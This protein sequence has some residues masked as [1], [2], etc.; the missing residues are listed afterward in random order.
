MICTMKWALVL[1][2]GGAKGLAYIG[3]LKAFEELGFPA[4]DFIAGCSMGGIIGGLYAS[5]M[6][7]REMEYFF[8]HEFSIE[9]Y[10]GNI[11]WPLSAS[12]FARFL[13]LGAGIPH[14]LSSG[15]MDSGERSHL[16]FSRLSN[17]QTFE[18]LTIPFACNA[19]DLYSGK[20]IILHSGPLAAALRATSS[21]PG[22]FAPMPIGDYL[23]VDGYILHNTPVW[24]AREYGFTNIIAVTLSSFETVKRKD[25]SNAAHVL[26]R[27][28][29]VAV[30]GNTLTKS[31]YPTLELRLER[32]LDTFN[33]NK[34]LKQI[35][36][37]YEQ[38]LTQRRVL[39]QFFLS[40]L[41]GVA[42]RYFLERNT[43]KTFT[44]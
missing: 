41:R 44:V 26:L 25:I 38:T 24:I 4:P 36:F 27:T 11:H 17:Y 31:D 1:S 37:G 8:E 20:E 19:A 43:K 13:Q 42:A 2:G 14:L 21:F 18:G 6:T 33:F 40:G 28:L 5:G 35:N 15:G 23:L 22:V 34:P 12:P 32:V 7:V 39:E 30:G 3:M 29:D 10:F 9:K 16:L